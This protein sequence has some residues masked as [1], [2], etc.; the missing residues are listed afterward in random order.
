MLNTARQRSLKETIPYILP[1]SVPLLHRTALSQPFTTTTQ[2]SSQI[3]RTPLSIPPSVTFSVVAAPVPKTGGRTARRDATPS[4]EIRGPL[5]ELSMPLPPF[6][7]I[8][9]D[10]AARKANVKV[11]DRGEREQREMWGAYACSP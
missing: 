10:A 7:K 6:L 5:G 4:V 8:D 2:C 1:S 3:G 9:Y 11:V